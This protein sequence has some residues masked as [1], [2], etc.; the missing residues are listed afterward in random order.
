MRNFRRRI[1]GMIPA[2]AWRDAELRRRAKLLSDLRADLKLSDASGRPAQR[3]PPASF[4]QR[5]GQ[6]QRD[7]VH[8]RD[9]DPQ[10]RHPLRQLMYKLRTYRLAQSH[11]ISVPQV[12]AVWESAASI[13]TTGLPDRFVLKSDG[14]SGSQGVL[15]LRRVEGGRLTTLDGKRM[16]DENGVRRHFASRLAAGRVSGPFFA[17]V[18]LE[19]HGGGPSLDDVKLFA[20]YGRVQQVLLRRVPQHGEFKRNTY[21]YLSAQG[22]D[23]GHAAIGRSS[24][25]SIGIP[26]ALF[27]LVRAAEHL[28]RA[29]GL[30]FV[31]VDMFAASSGIVLGELSRNPGGVHRFESDHDARMGEGWELAARRLEL[32]LLSGRPP[33]VLHGLYPA[34]NPYPAGHVSHSGDATPWAPVR[35]PCARWC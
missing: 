30:P 17:E 22:E 8:L 35:V 10:R 26:E 28:S 24:D 13:D 23:V 20:T 11:G 27:D 34:P 4:I 3:S 14:G 9:M 21:R 32:D 33:G 29:V 7:S 6:V 16:F 19:Q 31:R 15:P 12:L 5:V 2:L 1:V 18:L 25:Q